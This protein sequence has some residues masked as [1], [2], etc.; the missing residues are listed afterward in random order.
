MENYQLVQNINLLLFATKRTFPR[1]LT[2]DE[3][4]LHA[5][6][7]FNLHTQNLVYFYTIYN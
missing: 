5:W 3:E 7:I 2:H 6:F 4:A 1:N